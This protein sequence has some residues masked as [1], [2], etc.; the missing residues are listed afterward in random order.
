MRGEL[1]ADRNQRISAPIRRT[2]LPR[3]LAAGLPRGLLL[4]ACPPLLALC[5]SCAPDVEPLRPSR[6]LIQRMGEAVPLE[7]QGETRPSVSLRSGERRSL[8]VDASPGDRLLFAFGFVDPGFPCA[9]RV[10]VKAGPIVLMDERL[11][12]EPARWRLRALDM[13]PEG[14]RRIS[15][16]ADADC[17]EGSPPGDGAPF[18]IGSPRLHD[19]RD[20]HPDRVLVWI[21]QDT[22]RADHLGPWGYPRDTAPNLSRRA[23]DWV[24]FES[25]SATASW[26]LPS[27]A[28]QMTSLHPSFHGAVMSALGTDA[29]SVFESLA[30]NG[31]T[32]LGSSSNEF[33]SP[34]HSLTRGFDALWYVERRARGQGREL[35][36]RLAEW[37]GGDLALFVHFLDPHLPYLAPSPYHSSFDDQNYTGEIEGGSGFYHGN[38]RIGPADLQHLI[39]LYDE[40]IAYNDDAIERFL[41]ALAELDLLQRAVLVYSSDHGEEFREHGGWIHGSTLYEEV[42][43]VPLALRVP[44]IPPGR[45]RRPISLI[46]LPPTL[47]DA[48]GIE[49]PPSFQGRSLLPLMRGEPRA[50]GPLFAETVYQS[51]RRQVLALRSEDLKYIATVPRDAGASPPILSEELFDLEADP[52]ESR[53]LSQTRPKDLRA[54]RS[55]ALEYLARARVEGRRGHPVDLSPE[56][57]A[58]LRAWGYIE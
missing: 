12:P 39:D 16:R 29:P 57:L 43:H 54:L 35:I 32:V 14:A 31:F 51:Q 28:S 52:A 21:S 4:V 9:A 53:D 30:A 8:P 3:A 42:I 37:E 19:P 13:P 58:R 40:E 25:A 44:G 26:T 36:R 23:T 10:T 41:D 50:S 45:V 55:V 48:L 2:S 34:E 7:L 22:L 56:T 49:S 24:V 17:A 20:R 27:L 38:P 11:E 18:A 33:V 47:L 46:D 6:H 15:F 5:V 1:G